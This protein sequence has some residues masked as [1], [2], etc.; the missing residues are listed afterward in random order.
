MSTIKLDD[1]CGNLASH[2]ELM[3]KIMVI[4]LF[5]CNL[6]ILAVLKMVQVAL[7]YKLSVLPVEFLCSGTYR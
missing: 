1:Q 3:L 7:R 4:P 2:N 6:C 5:Q